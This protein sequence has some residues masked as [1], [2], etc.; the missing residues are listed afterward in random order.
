MTLRLNGIIPR[1]RHTISLPKSTSVAEY[2]TD[3]NEVGYDVLDWGGGGCR[4][5]GCCP[6]FFSRL[7]N[8]LW[9]CSKKGREKI[10]N[11]LPPPIALTALPPTKLLLRQWGT[12]RVF[13]TRNAIALHF[14]IWFCC[15]FHVSEFGDTKQ[16][17]VARRRRRLVFEGNCNEAQGRRTLGFR[18]KERGL[19]RKSC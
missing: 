8:A 13:Q 10:G 19:W 12:H 3:T 11:V 17:L 14:G 1:R 4:E 18:V 15:V 9:N 7:Q 5:K 16:K 6:P 2:A